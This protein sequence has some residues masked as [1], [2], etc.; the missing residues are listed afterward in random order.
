MQKNPPPLLLILKAITLAMSL[1]S[2]S[3]GIL[4]TAS[5][6]THVTLL[7]IGMFTLALATLLKGQ[8]PV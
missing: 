8:E 7:V 2:L 3:M 6:E 1:A 4:K 5:L